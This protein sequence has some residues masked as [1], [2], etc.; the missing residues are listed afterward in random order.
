MTQLD[1][2]CVEPYKIGLMGTLSFFSIAI[3]SFFF[4]RQ[5]DTYGRKPVILAA[6]MVTPIGVAL[7]LLLGTHLTLYWIYGILIMIALAYNPR[8]STAYLYATEVLPKRRRMLFGGTLFTFEGLFTVSVAYYFYVYRDQNT[9]M[10]G[11]S[12][13]CILAMIVL[14]FF[15]PESPSFLLITG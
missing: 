5:A 1:L 12:V 13:A 3:G 11:V 9:I 15:L 10:I 7:I 2:I 6:T 8:A 4:T 14:F